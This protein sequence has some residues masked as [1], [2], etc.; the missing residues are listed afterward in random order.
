MSS[1][2]LEDLVYAE[3][4]RTN[5]N[6]LTASEFSALHPETDPA[7]LAMALNGLLAKGWIELFQVR[8]E[9]I[10]KAVSKE[11]AGKAGSLQGEEQVVYSTIRA[12]G[13]EGI[14]TKHLKSK[15]NLHEA[16]IKRCLRALEQKALVKAIKSVKHPTRKLYMLMELTPSVEVTG[17]PWFTDQELDVEFVESLTVACYKYISLKSFPRDASSVFTT[18]H[19]S[20]PSATHVHKYIMEKRISQVDLTVDDITMLLDVLVYD[21][22]IER[23]IAQV[24]EDWGDEG[25][26][27]MDS[28]WVYKA[29]T[30]E[31]KAESAWQDCPCGYCPVADF[32]TESGP[33]NP[34]G[35]TYYAKWLEF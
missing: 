7:A 31:K 32:C 24:D 2:E 10:Y 26:L 23:F 29:V 13:N 27:D 20:Y 19:K 18:S 11:E 28:D 9:L 34:A 15:T 1:K 5:P 14:W 22:K 16:V 6:G 3:C 8:G 17:G 33:V 4:V 25:D 21:G 30:R 12:S 35:C